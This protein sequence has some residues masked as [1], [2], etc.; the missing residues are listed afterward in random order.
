[1]PQTAWT[2]FGS[3]ATA[4]IGTI[5]YIFYIGTDET[6]WYFTVDQNN[7]F[8][9]YQNATQIDMSGRPIKIPSTKKCPL[10]A[11][12]DSG[13]NIHLFYPEQTGTHPTLVEIKFDSRNWINGTL[14]RSLYTLHENSSISTTNTLSAPLAVYYVDPN[15]MIRSVW[16]NSAYNWQ[17]GGY[18]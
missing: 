1:M 18:P 14:Q 6:L 10:A 7:P 3:V 12:V 9:T 17:D 15:N 5:T 13:N 2:A 16:L 4:D 8:T 11:A